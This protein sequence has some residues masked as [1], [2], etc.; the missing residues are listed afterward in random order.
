[1]IVWFLSVALL[2]GL[3]VW[4]Y[5]RVGPRQAIAAAALLTL[6][7]PQWV[8]WDVTSGVW[9]N[10]PTAVTVAMLALY[11]F[12]PAATFD[13][14][15]RLC[16]WAMIAMM[17]IHLASDIV[18]D[19]FEV[20]ILLRMYG[21]WF[22]PYIA[23]RLAF[24][25]VDDIRWAL[26]MAVGVALALTLQGVVES[27]LSMKSNVFEILVMQNRP[28]EPGI[29]SN[30]ANAS[31]WGLKRAYG[32]LMHSLYFGVVQVML[33]PWLLYAGQLLS[34]ERGLSTV[35][36][37]WLWG[38]PVTAIGV[39]SSLSR[40][41]FLAIGAM[42]YATYW[43]LT[44]R[45][46]YVLGVIGVVAMVAAAATSGPLLDQLD[47]LTGEDIS[48]QTTKAGEETV[49]YTST[50]ARKL[51]FTVYGPPMKSA[52]LL[53][54]GTRACSTFPPKVPL[55]QPPGR[56]KAVD[57]AYI[58]FTLRFGYLGL[59]AFIAVNVTAAWQFFVLADEAHG[60]VRVWLA[61]M[62]GMVVSAMLMFMLVWMPQDIGF[63]YLFSLGA[64]S[65]LVLG[66]KQPPEEKLSEH[67]RRRR[68]SSSSREAK[69]DEEPPMRPVGDDW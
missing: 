21:E 18:N 13:F 57:N 14:R 59:L 15:L 17:G 24:Q 55:N 54:Y 42:V 2:V 31:R 39:A 4:L 20:S 58:L 43:V 64:A 68:R 48:G 30:A 47:F 9:I 33:M 67:K 61:A 49:K 38:I 37:G 45:N 16:D 69:L 1:M 11:A 60:D 65:G 34:Q 56:V 25:R 27:V 28:V 51:L 3:C 19:G 41:P 50:G 46:R 8:R 6:L 63:P 26:P 66:G 44:P 40:G 29:A 62:A 23:G 12:H 32:P 36:K 7:V 10:V 53:G 35:G 5:V 22:M 52:G